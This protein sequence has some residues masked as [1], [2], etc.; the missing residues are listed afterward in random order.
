M[1]DSF[2]DCLLSQLIEQNAENTC[3]RLLQFLTQ[4]PGNSLP[5]PIRVCGQENPR[6]LLSRCAK[7]LDHLLLSADN[8]IFRDKALVDF[9]TQFR[10]WQVLDGSYRRL[11]LIIGTKVLLDSFCFS[12]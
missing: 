8:L 9:D 11:H 5:L 3:C 2:F 1:S 10:L 7:F 6:S 4:M 12:R